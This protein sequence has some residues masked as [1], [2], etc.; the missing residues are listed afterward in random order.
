[1]EPE[2]AASDLY[3]LYQGKAIMQWTRENV[4]KANVYLY[5]LLL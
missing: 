5:G 1:M 2:A 4:L 3:C